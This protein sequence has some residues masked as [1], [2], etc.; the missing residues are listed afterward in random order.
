MH[1]AHCHIS[2][3]YKIPNFTN[4]SNDIPEYIS[5]QKDKSLTELTGE[6]QWFEQSIS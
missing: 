5:E 4:L 2:V 3:I 6:V 1:I